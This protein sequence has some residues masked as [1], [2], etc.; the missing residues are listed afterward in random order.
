MENTNQPNQPEPKPETVK[1]PAI[2]IY[3]LYAVF[4]VLGIG[5]AKVAFDIFSPR[6]IKP[7]AKSASP[8]VP[9]AAAAAP[10][11][12]KAVQDSPLD[13]VKKKIKQTAV[14][15]ELNGLYIADDETYALVNNKIVQEGD[16]VDGATV[17]AI[18][19]E[20]VELKHNDKIIRLTTRGK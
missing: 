6:F 12:A 15:F 11:A 18:S 9:K 8:Y 14:P 4:I 17:V 16:L 5:V 7:A 1:K 19:E 3:V 13:L 10:A 2:A 20:N